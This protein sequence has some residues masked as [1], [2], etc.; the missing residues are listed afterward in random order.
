MT[1]EQFEVLED[2]IVHVPTGARFDFYP[3]AQRI[4][5]P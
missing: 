2:R 5:R 1:R 3:N 4:F